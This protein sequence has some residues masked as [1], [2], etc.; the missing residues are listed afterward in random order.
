MAAYNFQ[1]LFDNIMKQKKIKRNIFSFYFDTTLGSDES[2]FILGGVD[3]RL[4]TESVKYFP[5]IDKYYWTIEGKKILVNKNDLGICSY[6]CKLVA[7]TGTSLITGPTK[8]VEAL[9][10]KFLD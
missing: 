6:G 5:V 4:I 1:P 2:K 10:R 7:D 8:E 3:E 9:L